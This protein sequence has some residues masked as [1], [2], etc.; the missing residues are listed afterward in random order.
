M[1]PELKDLSITTSPSAPL[2]TDKKKALSLTAGTVAF[3]TACLFLIAGL[4][5]F[6]FYVLKN[7][8]NAVDKSAF[9]K[10]Y[11]DVQPYNGY[12][13]A[14]YIALDS[15]KNGAPAVFFENKR[16]ESLKSANQKQNHK[17]PLPVY[18]S[19]SPAP[20]EHEP[21]L[22]AIPAKRLA[23]V[24]HAPISVAAVSLKKENIRDNAVSLDDL[25]ISGTKIL[26]DGDE[27]I[28]EAAEI[29]DAFAFDAAKAEIFEPKEE[30][31]ILPELPAD[32]ASPDKPPFT[33]VIRKKSPAK[34]VWI[35]VAALRRSLKEQENSALK[36]LA[37]A[38]KKK[39]V[40]KE[41]DALL[42]MGGAKQLASL[43]N[44]ISSDTGLNASDK[45]QKTPENKTTEAENTPPLKAVGKKEDENVKKAVRSKVAQAQKKAND[46][47]VQTESL[48]KIAVANGTPK[49]KLAVKK[50]ETENEKIIAI[51]NLAREEADNEKPSK[52]YIEVK[53]SF[54]E[55]TETVIYRNGKPHKIFNAD[56][57]KEQKTADNSDSSLNWLDRQQAAVWTSMAQSDTP[58][59]W[60]LSSN[61]T[62]HNPE[63]AKAFKVADVSEPAPQKTS[64]TEKDNEKDNVLTS[65]EVR[66]V[67]EE[68]KPE[69]K[70]S[71]LLLPL[72]S[73]EPVSTSAPLPAAVMPSSSPGKTNQSS[74]SQP[75][76]HALPAPA[77][78]ADEAQN[79]QDDSIVG[80]IKALFSSSDT[81]PALPDLGGGSSE[82]LPDLNK[83]PKT[84]TKTASKKSKK[85]SSASVREDAFAK[86]ERNAKRNDEDEF[87]SELRLTFKPGNAELTSTSVKWVKAFG[88]RAKKDIQ[89]GIEVRMS[90]QIR[91]IQEK[92]FAII[93]SILLGTGMEPTQL[94]PVMTNRTPHTIVLRAFDIPEEGYEEYT[95]SGNGVEER[96]YF[97]QW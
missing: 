79:E 31:K 85:A 59:V 89:R 66:V 63:T 64:E 52:E 41:N 14:D 69:A 71:P 83:K 45:S 50:P 61:D 11:I 12:K 21:T 92:R 16:P 1:K 95:S 29:E 22:R 97:K 20:A 78:F 36:I 34:T 25:I 88:N 87:P 27:K 33:P 86:M 44:E 93:R 35:D 40:K 72:G 43:K 81:A 19:V 73:S 9:V 24:V 57:K 42:N 70:K 47:F 39:A 60:T 80:K 5:R 68:K 94:F 32:V 37:A 6:S 74:P 76:I 51:K 48:W 75:V 56:G 38:E 90:N 26:D 65:A 10:T 4:C 15:F 84:S 77:P 2:Q 23:P 53:N 7:H 30:K 62:P 17:P 55:P 13:N 54:E 46:S 91:D 8:R 58:S 96:I 49:N 82:P 67:G 3:F 18:A 28:A